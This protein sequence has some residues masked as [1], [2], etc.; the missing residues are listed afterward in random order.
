L[1]NGEPDF[2]LIEPTGVDGQMNESEAGPDRLKPLDGTRAAVHRAIVHDPEHPLGRR[3]R[4]GAHDL[5]AAQFAVAIELNAQFD[6]QIRRIARARRNVPA[7]LDLPVRHLRT[8]AGSGSM[9]DPFAVD[10]VLA[11]PSMMALWHF[12]TKDRQRWHAVK[13][14]RRPFREPVADAFDQALNWH[15]LT[16]YA[17]E[18]C[19]EPSC[20]HR[21]QDE[22]GTVVMSPLGRAAL[23]MRWVTDLLEE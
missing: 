21:H 15:G 1:E 3:I 8:L 10:P 5:G 22:S 18:P 17:D 14:S 20:S 12:L 2:D 16:W 4:L 19:L 13:L 6:Y 9:I 11:M 23:C 7:S